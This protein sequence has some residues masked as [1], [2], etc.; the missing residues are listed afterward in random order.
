M[1]KLILASGSPRRKEILSLLNIPFEIHSAD[2]D[3]T[4]DNKKTIKEEIQRLSYE[5]A[6]AVFSS[7]PEDIVIGSDTVVIL[8][9]QILGKPQTHDQAYQML[10]SLSGRS[11]EVLTAITILSKE[12]QETFS[13]VSKVYFCKMTEKEL[14]FYADSE[15]PMDK[16]GAYAIQG[17]GGRFIEK[18]EGDYNT[19]VGLPLHLLYKH[20]KNYSAFQQNILQ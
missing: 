12:K 2:I 1:N 15:E 11:H 19:I 8:D 10:K 4:I 16:A 7:Y 18:I 9:D 14:H 3:E 5:K 17:I 13:S 6:A 20:L